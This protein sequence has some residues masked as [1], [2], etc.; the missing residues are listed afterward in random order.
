LA[1]MKKN[2]NLAEMK[3]NFNQ[4]YISKNDRIMP[5]K[6]QKLYWEGANV[7]ELEAGHFPFYKY[8][9]IFDV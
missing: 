5:Y 9:N 6:S 7:I 8:K 2:F 1:E 3:K 4:V